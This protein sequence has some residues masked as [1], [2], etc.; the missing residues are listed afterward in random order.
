M[1]FN[2]LVARLR[3][4]YRDAIVKS[5]RRDAFDRL[6]EAWSSE[7]GAVTYA[8][9]ISMLDLM[10]L[11]AAVENRRLVQDL[12]DRLDAQEKRVNT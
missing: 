2:D 1:S 12:H 4:E 8:E 9:S 6:V 10:L 7:L 3:E 11:T 5:A